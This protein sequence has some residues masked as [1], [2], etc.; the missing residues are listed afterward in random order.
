ML[1][2]WE[3]DLTVGARYVDSKVCGRDLEVGFGT[4]YKASG[5]P[6]KTPGAKY[7][8]V[9]CN[10][11]VQEV[12][13]LCVFLSWGSTVVSKTKVFEERTLLCCSEH[14]MFTGPFL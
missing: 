5:V 2:N 3:D 8:S 12:L 4:R 1:F 9:S 10:L 14:I 6:K 11:T 7:H 13:D